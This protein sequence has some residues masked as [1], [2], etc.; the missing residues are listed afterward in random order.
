MEARNPSAVVARF[1]YWAAGNVQA[2]DGGQMYQIDMTQSLDYV[3]RDRS[4][5]DRQVACDQAM[6]MIANTVTV[7]W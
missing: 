1:P 4:S 7:R 6:R 2:P 5:N 3:K